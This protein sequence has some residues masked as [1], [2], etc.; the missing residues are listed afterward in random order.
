VAQTPRTA[1]KVQSSDAGKP[2]LFV[3]AGKLH[4]TTTVYRT[5]VTPTQNLL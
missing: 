2:N 3:K 5:T 1:A 4:R